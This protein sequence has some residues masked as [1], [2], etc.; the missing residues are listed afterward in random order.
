MLQSRTH[1]REKVKTNS[2][3]ILQQ[4]NRVYN[5]LKARERN[6]VITEAQWNEQVVHIQELKE[7][8]L[9]GKIT[10]AELCAVPGP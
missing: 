3:P 4:Y 7:A 2:K 9:K 1:K 6:G 8:A 10:D 5:R